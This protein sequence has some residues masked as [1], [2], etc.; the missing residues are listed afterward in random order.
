[1]FCRISLTFSTSKEK[2]KQLILN[3]YF[4]YVLYKNNFKITYIGVNYAFIFVSGSKNI[5]PVDINTIYMKFKPKH[6]Y[7]NKTRSSEQLHLLNFLW[8]SP[9][10]NYGAVSPRV[11]SSVHVPAGRNC[12]NV[13][14]VVHRSNLF[15]VYFWNQNI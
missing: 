4:N 12:C 11:V 8:N 9:G 3:N 15:H 14:L 10:P 6:G 5:S 7:E 13:Q 2:Y 1:M